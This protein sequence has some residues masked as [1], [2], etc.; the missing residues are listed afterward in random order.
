MS[1][2]LSEPPGGVGNGD[3]PMPRVPGFT[4]GSM[5]LEVAPSS[6]APAA[7]GMRGASGSSRNATLCA[8]GSA[9][10]AVGGGVTTAA[11]RSLCRAASLAQPSAPRAVLAGN[12]APLGSAASMPASAASPSAASSP[13]QPLPPAPAKAPKAA[14]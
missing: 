9:S 12:A 11:P 3:K 5:A 8:D 14:R 1:P 10:G 6:L 13:L 4:V 2:G 7:A